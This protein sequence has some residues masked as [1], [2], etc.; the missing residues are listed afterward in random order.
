MAKPMDDLN[1]V[2][3]P[4]FWADDLPDHNRVTLVRVGSAVIQVDNAGVRLI[5]FPTAGRA[6]LWM[7]RVAPPKPVASFCLLEHE[8]EKH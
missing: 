1:D 6:L 8:K 4:D 2:T 7:K 5:R 3:I